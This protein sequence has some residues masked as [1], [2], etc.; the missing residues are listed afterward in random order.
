MA[1]LTYPRPANVRGKFGRW[2]TADL[3]HIAQRL[4]EIEQ[5]NRLFIQ[6]FDGP[7]RMPDGQIWNFVVVEVDEG[8]AQWW[9]TPARELDA[10]LIEHVQYLL[11][12]PFNKRFEEAEKLI[13]KREQEEMDRQLDEALENWG[14]DFRKQLAHDGFITHTG[15]SHP[16]RAIHPT[17]AEP[18][19]R[20]SPAVNS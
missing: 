18:S 11:K 7:R 16:T 2:V 8:G 9:V 14:W 15:R 12:V 5:G 20:L 1:E 4:Q 19:W 17:K 6:A 3:F 13:A 10:R